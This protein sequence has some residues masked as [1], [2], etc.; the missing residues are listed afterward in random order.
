MENYDRDQN[1]SRSD[2][3]RRTRRALA[4]LCSSVPDFREQSYED[5]IEFLQGLGLE[6]PEVQDVIEMHSRMFEGT[7]G[8]FENTTNSGPCAIPWS[9]NVASPVLHG[10]EDVDKET[11]NTHAF[12][13]LSDL[14]L[15][16]PPTSLRIFYPTITRGRKNVP[17]LGNCGRYPLIVFLHGQCGLQTSQTYYKAWY[18]LPAQVARCGYVVVV[19]QLGHPVPNDRDLALATSVVDWMR[20]HWRHRSQLAQAMG[21]VGHSRGAILG[22]L[23]STRVPTA[24]LVS[25][26]GAWTEELAGFP[27]LLEDLNVPVLFT[28]GIFDDITVDLTSRLIPPKHHILF[29]GANHFDYL[30][31]GNRQECGQE[32]DGDCDIV[33]Q[34]A[35]DFTALFLSRYMPPPLAPVRIGPSLRLPDPG[36]LTSEQEDYADHHLMGIKL[37]ECTDGCK[38]THKWFLQ[39]GESGTLMLP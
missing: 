4:Y 11:L 15:T 1:E 34:L 26:D 9:P 23:L 18:Y 33:K 32:A 22:G 25:L 39:G 24:A 29:H 7:P 36:P 14:H 8:P 17:L 37:I 12:V 10:Y 16:P 19:P 35:G 2:A 5:R 27:N 6:V 21:V 31:K 30:P 28:S 3:E 20:K 13:S 38:V